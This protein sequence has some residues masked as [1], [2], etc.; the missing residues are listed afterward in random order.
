MNTT[1]ARQACQNLS[2]AF[3]G[4]AFLMVNGGVVCAYCGRVVPFEV[5]VEE[6]HAAGACLC[7]ERCYRMA[8]DEPVLLAGLQS[9]THHGYSRALHEQSP[10]L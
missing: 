8:F 9:S 5:Q 2:D 6:F 3:E 7:S 4:I 1:T 10:P